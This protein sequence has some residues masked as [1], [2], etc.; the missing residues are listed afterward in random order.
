MTP[1]TGTQLLKIY[2]ATNADTLKALVKEHNISYV[3]VENDNRNSNEYRLNE[4]LIETF[5]QVYINGDYRIFRT[6]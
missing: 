5:E 4:Q 3:V 6:Y 1:R 2:S